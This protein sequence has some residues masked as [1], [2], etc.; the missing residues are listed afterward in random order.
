MNPLNT[1]TLNTVAAFI[2]DDLSVFGG[3]DISGPLAESIED[4]DIQV[5]W[6]SGAGAG[7]G[8][9]VA[10]SVP[11]GLALGWRGL[12]AGNV[13]A[14]YAGAHVALDVA[15]GPGDNLSLS[16]SLDVGIDLTL[17]NIYEGVELES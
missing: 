4:A 15:S 7:V 9:E 1:L 5:L 10:L 2:A 11:V 6:W 14:P 17:A 8:N 13:F 16:G 3:V 12:G